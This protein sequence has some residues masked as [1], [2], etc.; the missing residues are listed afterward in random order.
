MEEMNYLDFDIHIH[1]SDQGYRIRIVNSPAGQADGEFNIPFSDLELENFKL[2]IGR[3]R[4]GVRRLESPEME[5]AR[6]MGGRLFE[7]VFDDEI[8][9]HLR[10]SVNEADQQNAG[11]RF[12][13]HL[14][15][16]P[17]LADLPWEYMY[18]STLDE[19]LVLSVQ[20]PIVR[21]LDLPIKTTPLTTTLPLKILVM[22]S[23]PSDYPELDV[24]KEFETLVGGLA[25]LQQKG[26]VKLEKLEEATLASLQRQLRKDD[27][28]IFH[29][30]GHG[31]YDQKAEDG[32]LV[33]EDENGRGR[34]VSGRYLGTMLHDQKSLSLAVLN[35]CEGAI[36]SSSDP[37]SGVAHSLVQKGIPAVIAMQNE[38]TD[39]AAIVLAHE[40]Y[41]A[42]ADG[43]PVDA[44]LGEA[45][46]AVFAQ[47]NDIEWGTPVLYMRSPDGRIFGVDRTTL[48]ASA[49]AGDGA[50]DLQPM[51]SETV[52]SATIAAGMA[53]GAA[54]QPGV[55]ATQVGYG[56]EGG[57]TIGIP[58]APGAAAYPPKRKRSIVPWL[59]AFVGIAALIV[60]ALIFLEV[61]DLGAILGLGGEPVPVAV[62]TTTEPATEEIPPTST[63]EPTNTEMPTA[64]A[65][66]AAVIPDTGPSPMPTDTATL[67]PTPT[68]EPTPT[69][70]PTPIGGGPGTIAFASNREGNFQIWV[71]DVD[72]NNA[73]KITNMPSGA[74]QPAWSPDGNQL[75]F[76]SPC[77]KDQEWYENSALY[78][79]N[80]G[81]DSERKLTD[82]INGDYDPS[83]APSE[84]ILFTSRESNQPNLYTIDPVLGGAPKS[85]TQ[86]SWNYRGD[87]SADGQSIAFVS[88]RLSPVPKVF[89]MPALGEL[90]SAGGQAKEFSRGQEFAYN[91]PRYSPDGQFLMF[92]KTV[93]NTSSPAELV[94][95]KLED[96]GLKESNIASY[97]SVGPFNDA[98]YSPD[99]KWIVYEGWPDAEHNI[100]IMTANGSNVRQVTSGG[101][102]NFDPAWRPILEP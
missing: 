92:R 65:E 26:L 31:G 97:Q 23:S 85:L 40:F 57:G 71:S 25:D 45:R 7:S 101:S 18:D 73:T 95:S 35:A 38:I 80:L 79:I 62:V 41:G 2:R 44:S 66:E 16:S 63:P 3:P 83:W 76:I 36:T 46:K 49:L 96:I 86:H 98:D 52:R 19:F 32:V 68:E 24:N 42:I 54:V 67:E 69:M 94:G 64:T 82:G 100:Y 51:S 48:A 102:F 47:N 5:A 29:F 60:T 55:P 59:I 88:T 84:L 43:Y 39:E 91:Q 11:L 14:T 4:K 53:A 17:E 13:L 28:H 15:D 37:F 50:Q 12:R 90:D 93:P 78:V 70:G 20:T 33:L 99:G 1:R 72:G 56:G 61:I 58:A 9:G 89:T 10:T 30:I 8:R 77:T 75:V 81:V 21:Y 74:C 22:I 6:Q 27:Y 34:E 87:W